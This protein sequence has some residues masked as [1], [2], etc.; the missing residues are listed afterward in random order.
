MLAGL[1][2]R[3]KTASEV[4][5]FHLTKVTMNIVMKRTGVIFRAMLLW[6]AND[7]WTIDDLQAVRD[8]LLNCLVVLYKK[9]SIVYEGQ[10]L[11]S[12]CWRIFTQLFITYGMFVFSHCAI[13]TSALIWLNNWLSWLLGACQYLKATLDQGASRDVIL[14]NVY[15]LPFESN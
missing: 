8:I 7:S 4:H 10:L 6:D 3:T 1:I 2:S 9:A 14:V 5:F 15:Y 11:T 12:Y 13:T